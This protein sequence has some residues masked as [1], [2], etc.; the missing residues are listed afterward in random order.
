MNRNRIKIEVGS[1]VFHYSENMIRIFRKTL[2]TFFF[3]AFY[4]FSAFSGNK[5]FIK[6]I[7]IGDPPKF[8]EELPGDL[9]KIPAN[10][11]GLPLKN[12]NPDLIKEFVTP[13]LGY[14]ES[15]FYWWIGEKLE[16][17]R[18]LWQMDQ[19][20]EK[21]VWGLVISIH[22]TDK[23]IFNAYKT[24]PVQYSD[25]WWDLVKWAADECEKRGMTLGINDYVHHY[26]GEG[27]WVDDISAEYPEVFGKQMICT[28][29]NAK[30]GDAFECGIPV[31]LLN[32][33]A[34]RTTERNKIV[35]GALSVD[36]SDKI[37]NNK[38]QWTPPS[39]EWK[40][41]VIS[42]KTNTMSFDAMNPVFGR[43][44]IKR[45]YQRFEDKLPGRMGKSFNIFDHDEEG[46]FWIDGAVWNDKFAETFQKRHGYDIVPELSALFED[47]G[48][49]TPK[50]R[51]DYWETLS[52]LM[53]EAYFKPVSKWIDQRGMMHW[54]DHAG[55]GQS[56]G[57][58]G[59]YMNMIRWLTPGMDQWG[60]ERN[61]IKD[62]VASS[63]T[64]LYD[65]HRAW[66][67]GNH[68]IGWG[69]TPAVLLDLMHYHYAAG[70]NQY[71]LHGLYYSTL[72]GWWEWAPPCFHFRMPYWNHAETWF[73]YIERLSYL[74]SQ[75][76]HR[77]DV[78]MLYPVT[79]SQSV[80]D[81][82]GRKFT[83]C[84][85]ATADDLFNCGVDFDFI[86]DSSIQRASIDNGKLE[87][88]GETYRVL[89]LP[90]M[91]AISYQ[92]MEKILAFYRAGGKVVALDY[93]SESS[94]RIGRDDPVLA[95]M[96][97]EIFGMSFMDYTPMMLQ[98]KMQTNKNG[99]I[100]FFARRIPKAYD[101]LRS[102][103]L[104]AILSV[105]DKT[106]IRD[107]EWINKP[108]GYNKAYH[109]NHR[110]VGTRDIYMVYGIPKDAECA[111]R[112][113][114]KVELWDAW[115]GTTKEIFETRRKGEQTIVKMPLA[116]TESQLIVFNNDKSENI[117]VEKSNLIS[118]TKI[119]RENG[120]VTVEGT[121]CSSGDKTVDIR[122]DGKVISLKKTVDA[123]SPIQVIS[124]EW[125]FELIPT[126]DNRWGDF[127][128][129]SFNDM[130][131]AEARHFYYSEESKAS[132]PEKPTFDH[133]SW[134]KITY[135]YGPRFY[136]LGPLS[137]GDTVREKT[138]TVQKRP[139][140]TFTT[141]NQTVQNWEELC[142]SWRW[143]IESEPGTQGYHG[144]KGRIFNDFI[145]FGTQIFDPDKFTYESGENGTCNYLWT[146]VTR[147]KAGKVKVSFGAL[148]PTSVWLN[149][150]KINPR[151]A[152]MIL[153]KGVNTILVRFDG[154]GRTHYVLEPEEK[155]EWKQTLPLSMKWY[156]MPGLTEYNVRPEEKNPAG[157]YRFLSPPGLTEM[158][159]FIKCRSAKVWVNGIE[160]KVE[161]GT[162]SKDVPGAKSFNVKV[163]NPERKSVVV[164]VRVEQEPGIYGGAVFPE[165]I[166]LKCGKGAINTGD[167][168]QFGVMEDFS[169]GGLYRK[170]VTMTAEQVKENVILD[171]GNVSATAGV[172][173]NGKKVDVKVQPPWT[174]NISDYL[175]QGDNVVEVTV[176]NS[177]S[178]HYNTIPSLYRGDLLSGLLGPV[179][180]TF[181]K[182]IILHEEY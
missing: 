126:M 142:Y 81:D 112:S 14:G 37:V 60:T 35:S 123:P 67:E 31:E 68:S 64:H 101:L 136:R 107:F 175:K 124:G 113:T 127:R 65:R 25:E 132:G 11:V 166:G 170:I 106:A 47:I 77:C 92:T 157:W 109:V 97:D 62:K 182:K 30:G 44:I 3:V 121:A 38:L 120:K 168:S 73:K 10:T 130:I 1:D 161:I 141:V 84:A 167:W 70:M 88:A 51:M 144:L 137:L 181:E 23:H 98:T 40:I 17:D 169:G 28:D 180:I 43:E 162:T 61:I 66:L 176:Y 26:P 18:I 9:I 83:E 149:G 75:G 110:K 79:V 125:E 2:L 154:Y 15:P 104:N 48:P 151:A 159:G 71:S 85:F 46:W 139:G 95:S 99:G 72:G 156:G 45:F 172:S 102:N 150:K 173:I 105:L 133:S 4:S 41:K 54:I 13:P 52:F 178:N 63:A 94:D 29:Y 96:Q 152:E 55:R 140:H 114:G 89:V 177:L 16:K 100:G 36:L 82:E 158:K 118:I 135:G 24:D 165:P 58:F 138:L 129:P 164:A 117:F 20:K 50:I 21:H 163:N 42:Y 148:A 57:E 69:V 56:P 7:P 32:V 108:E 153:Q 80:M 128:L 87:I 143:G 111:F 39:G 155:T 160:Q 90:D 6:V 78:A 146:T 8:K 76:E 119:V 103:R 131:G 134:K 86:D 179:R 27:W 5:S 122:V 115:T 174:F 59:N 49:R 19:L 147:E 145:Q 53:Q 171:L 91:K 34:Y 93:L 12:A 33:R 116:V 74:M 22:H